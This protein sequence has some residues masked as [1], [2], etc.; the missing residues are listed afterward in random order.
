MS[1]G[2]GF[3][4]QQSCALLSIPNFIWKAKTCA[5]YVFSFETGSR[6]AGTKLTLTV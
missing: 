3:A 5:G 2:R 6:V 1:P 4:R